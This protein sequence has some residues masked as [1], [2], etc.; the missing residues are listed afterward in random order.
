MS[1]LVQ[2]LLAEDEP[3]DFEVVKRLLSKST[4]SRFD[5]QWVRTLE[6]AVRAAVV[7]TLLRCA[8]T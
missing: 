4:R 2:L 5:I 3:A 1:D 6:D 8:I 7:G